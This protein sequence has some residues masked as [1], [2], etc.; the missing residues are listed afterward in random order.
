MIN[1]RIDALFATPIYFSNL[2]RDLT[3]KEKN[4][5]FKNQEKLFLNSGGNKTSE[6]TYI[7]EKKEMQNLKK[8]LMLRVEDYNNTIENC[9]EKIDLYITQSW[10]NYNE[11]NTSHHAHFHSNS[12][13]S[14]VFYI[15]ANKDIDR[16]Y[17]LD[18]RYFQL[19]LGLRKNYNS[20]NS[21]EWNY[22]VKTGDLFLFPSHLKHRVDTNV[23]K[24]HIRISLAFNVFVKGKIGNKL[25]LTEL[26]INE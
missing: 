1:H 21:R 18:S 20:F 3:N 24:N 13:L 11:I 19:E 9:V 15:N 25:H 4:L 14:G 5:I 7:L 26:I 2:E 8:H 17:F 12:Y 23:T 10:L 16:I 22:P 6:D